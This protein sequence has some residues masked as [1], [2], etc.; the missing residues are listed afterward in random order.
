MN[1]TITLAE[2]EPDD[3]IDDAPISALSVAYCEDAFFG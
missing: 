2:L 1:E 3:P